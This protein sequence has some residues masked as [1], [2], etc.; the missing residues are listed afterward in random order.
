VIAAFITALFALF[1]H[2]MPP[3]VLAP[4]AAEH[5]VAPAPV[6]SAPTPSHGRAS[7]DGA[8]AGVPAQRPASP[9]TVDP[10]CLAGEEWDG[11]RCVAL[12]RPEETNG[13]QIDCPDAVTVGVMVNGVVT[14]CPVTPTR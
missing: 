6:A 9:A 4:A 1:A 11:L 7:A 12:Q 3:A 2:L 10:A 5:A 13:R 8:R 14:G